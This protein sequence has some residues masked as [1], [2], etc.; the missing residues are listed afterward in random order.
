MGLILDFEDGQ[1]P[2]KEA[3]KEG[4]L[5][6]SI[7]TVG[8]LNEFEQLNIEQAIFWT[9]HKSIKSEKLLT[10]RF[11]LNLHKRMYGQVWKWA[12]K[13]RKTEKNIGIHHWEIPGQI[14]YLL[15]DANYWYVNKSFPPNEFAIRIKH[16]LVSIH[17]FSNGNGRHSR[18]Y[19]DLIIEK[20]YGLPV[21]SW[22]SGNLSKECD[23]RK[24]YLNA[25]KQADQGHFEELIEFSRS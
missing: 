4:L 13:Y 12:G 10:D 20:L 7:S 18:L 5:I 9:L 19:A 16:R 15:D 14:K 24:T 22:G 3:E 11:I 6:K 21:F 1:T 2:L 17:C 25:L 23:P 8:D